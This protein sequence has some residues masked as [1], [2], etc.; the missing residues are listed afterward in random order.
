VVNGPL[1]GIL[2]RGRAFGAQNLQQKRAYPVERVQ[3]VRPTHAAAYRRSEL[4]LPV[5]ALAE[6]VEADNVVRTVRLRDLSRSGAGVESS[7]DLGPCA[8]LRLRIGH[9]DVAATLRWSR[10][11]RFGLRFDAPIRATDL[12]LL[13][14][15]YRG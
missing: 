12:L 10:G 15:R 11:T 4:R 2:V 14:S 1:T 13:A 3:A 6:L 8:R 7:R 9:L 5:S